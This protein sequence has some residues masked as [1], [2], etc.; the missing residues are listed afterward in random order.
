V[1]VWDWRT[2]GTTIA[3]TTT[4]RGGDGSSAPDDAIFG[5]VGGGGG[6]GGDGSPS[7]LTL[8]ANGYEP[9]VLRWETA[10]QI[11]VG[12]NVARILSSIGEEVVK[13]VVATTVFAALAAAVV[14]PVFLMKLTNHIDNVWT[15]AI[16]RAD[17]AGV[18]LAEALASRAHGQRAVTLVGQSLGA[19][20]VFACLTRLEEMSR[21]R[22]EHEKAAVQC[23]QGDGG[24]VAAAAAAATPAAS[25]PVE[26]SW[27]AAPTVAN[28][29]PTGEATDRGSGSG[30]DKL[31]TTLTSAELLDLVQHVYLLGAPL[32]CSGEIWGRARRACTGRFVNAFSTNDLVLAL[33][34]RY[35]RWK[36]KVTC[37]RESRTWTCPPSSTPTLTT[38]TACK[39]CWQRCAL[40]GNDYQ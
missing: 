31:P 11:E 20:T 28:D 4:T 32:G 16:E 8:G 27:S 3:A 29:R 17:Q 39:K 38:A 18:E 40:T 35:E 10:L 23:V 19:R 9:Y 25:G 12:H 15:M 30:S 21:E 37:A 14:L 34:Y 1:P 33:V 7:A 13:K 5:D 6:G 22:E 26:G 2:L 36:V 24:A